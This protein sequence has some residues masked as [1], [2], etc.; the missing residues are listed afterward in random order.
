MDL[1]PSKTKLNKTAGANSAA[2]FLPRGEKSSSSTRLQ[3]N[4]RAIYKPNTYIQNSE[5][6]VQVDI[7]FRLSLLQLIL[8]SYKGLRLK[9]PS[10]VKLWRNDITPPDPLC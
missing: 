10:I 9:N 8:H 7:Y 3:L 1:N 5:G 6:Y 2:E 4:T